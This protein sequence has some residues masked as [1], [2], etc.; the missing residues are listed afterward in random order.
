[1]SRRVAGSCT[2]GFRNATA[3]WRA[4]IGLIPQPTPLF[5]PKLP[6][7]AASALAYLHARTGKQEYLDAAVRAARYLTDQAWDSA[8]STFPF[9]PGSDRAYFFDIGIIVRGLLA[10]WR[11]TGEEEFRTRA[12]EAALSL[13]FDFLGDGVF[14]PVISLPDKQPLPEEPRWSRKPGCYQL[15]SA[16]AWREIGDPHA[17]Q[18]F[19]AA[20]RVALALFQLR[21]MAQTRA[22]SKCL[23]NVLAWVVVLAGY[24]PT[25]AEEMDGVFQQRTQSQGKPTVTPPQRKSE[26][27]SQTPEGGA[28]LISLE[29]FSSW[30][31][32]CNNEWRVPVPTLNTPPTPS[33]PCTARAS[34]LARSAT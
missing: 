17:R 22:C 5:R 28:R 18:M 15:K 29:S 20:V 33:I 8:A 1:M 34:N 32:N 12:Q 30:L 21:S 3:A 26:A 10:V 7:Y 9:E 4:S 16:L 11:A 27:P 2:P 6:G 23:R 24:R 19:D 14:H 31:N 13:A 25:P